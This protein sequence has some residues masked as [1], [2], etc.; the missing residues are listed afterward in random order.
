MASEENNT[1][2]PHHAGNQHPPHPD[3]PR[4][5]FHL[6]S[7]LMWE[8]FSYYGM[9]ALLVLYLTSEL[10]FSDGDAYA[11]YGA[12]TAMVYVTPVFGG[13]LADHYLGNRWA[14]ILGALFM[15]AGHL[16]LGLSGD[17]TLPLYLALSL[18]IVGYGLFK[19]NISCLLGELYTN[20]DTRREP[21]FA[22]MYVGGNIGA[23]L[24]GIG[25]GWV[26]HKY[27]WHAGFALAALGMLVGLAVFLSG[28]K[29]FT[30]TENPDW[31][32]LKRTSI[33]LPQGLW[34]IF[35]LCAATLLFVL[36][37]Q[38]LWAGYFLIIAGIC[39]FI[40]MARIY[41]RCN[42]NERKEL[43]LII[44]FMIFGI[45]FWAFN[46]QYGSSINLFIDRNID[47]ELGG[48]TVP[49]PIFQSINP[50]SVLLGGMILAW[51]WRFLSKR[52]IKPDT[53][54]KQGIGMV[55]LTVGF[56]LLAMTA[57]TA[58]LHGQAPIFGLLIGTFFIG[59]AELFIDPVALA[60]ITRLNPAQS[61]GTLA[62]IYMLLTGSV[63]N[64]LAGHIAMLAEVEIVEGVELDLHTAATTY[65]ATFS[66]ITMVAAGAVCL[67]VIVWL[68][69]DTSRAK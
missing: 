6:I 32:A 24:S 37:L 49:T 27:G 58:Q 30:S 42:S 69:I 48:F 44:W 23:V 65:F 41:A 25:C 54:A 3:Q 7:I 28:K 51:L 50:A 35:S 60:S 20:N 59:I 67:L 68:S 13:M 4:G 26:A 43:G 31:K 56:A 63:A 21:G 22:L 8:Y 15:V 46:Q 38:N 29:H 14:V 34:I 64:F 19:T 53:L 9:R 61:T 17:F 66:N 45:I 11:L 47:R 33:G 1:P 39:T 5:F 55:L 16:T 18:I 2:F 10:M 12:Y 36:I 57:K 40:L 62:G 52:G